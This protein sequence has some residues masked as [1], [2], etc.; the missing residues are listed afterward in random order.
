MP[1]EA[2]VQRYY[3]EDLPDYSWVERPEVLILCKLNV[4]TTTTEELNPEG[5]E[6]A[7]SLE[8]RREV[9]HHAIEIEAVEYSGRSLDEYSRARITLRTEF[10]S[11]GSEVREAVALAA[12][13]RGITTKKIS[14]FV[15]ASE[16]LD[17]ASTLSRVKAFL[18]NEPGN[19]YAEVLGAMKLLQ[20]PSRE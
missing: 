17:T 16:N 19:H 9:A 1:A 6:A 8:V 7:R 13:M 18:A 20:D 15:E 14:L 12:A 4:R 2:V 3:S 5:L 11:L 10:F